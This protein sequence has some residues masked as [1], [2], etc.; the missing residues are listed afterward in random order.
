MPDW[1]V[2]SGKEANARIEEL[3]GL[4]CEQFRKIVMLAQGEF[5]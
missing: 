4:N 5:L 2:L 3:L 1:E